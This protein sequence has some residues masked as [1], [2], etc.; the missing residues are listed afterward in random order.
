M[1]CRIGD[2][3]V[4]YEIV[5]EGK[6]AVL[7]HGF[8]L[9][10]RMMM[11]CMEPVF[12]DRPG[13]KRVYLDLPGMGRSGSAAWIKDSDAM[14]DVVLAAIDAVLPGERYLLAGESYGGY[15]ARG[16]L[17]RVPERVD[18]ALFICPLIG[19]NRV[20]PAHAVIARDETLLA[21]LSPDDRDGFMENNAVLTEAVYARYEQEILP[22]V[23]M[24]DDAFLA[25]LM[26]QGYYFSFEP[27]ARFDKPALFLLGRQDG[28]VG[29]RNAL[30][31]MERFPR[32]TFA[33]LDRAA[34]NL[35]IEQAG[36]FTPLVS[37]WLDRAAEYEQARA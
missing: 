11:A 7:L 12:A 33:V 24:A 4:H 26:A 2:V 20:L 15:I 1:E 17:H 13:Y 21:R 16:I 35:Q 36:L 6:P 9:D 3:S 37:E 18:G 27:D 8:H 31:I 29:Y 32:A 14:L 22:A 25:R 10:H 34:H 5:G 19:D 28:V 23:R 30:D